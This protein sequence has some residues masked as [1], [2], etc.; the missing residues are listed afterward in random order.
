MR[1]SIALFSFA[2][3]IVSPLALARID[4]K[5]VALAAETMTNWIPRVL[6]P[7]SLR[8]GWQYLFSTA[9]NAAARYLPFIFSTTD[10]ALLE[11]TNGAMRVVIN[12]VL[13]TRPAVSSA[14]A[15]G[16]FDTNL[17]SWTDSDEAGATS[18]WVT[19]GYMG[20]TG[21]GTS[22]A[23][24]D[25]QVTVA[26]GDQNVEHA[27]RIVIQ[28]GPVVL[29]V[30]SS[31][32][33]DSYINETTLNTG[34]H[35]LAFTPTGNFWIRFLS[36]LERQT[37]VN[38][39]NVEGSGVVSITSPYLA[40]DLANIR[41]DQSGDVIFVACPTYQQ[42]RIERRATRSWSIALY[43]ADDGP[44]MVE[45]TDD[46][47]TLTASAITGNIT[48]TASR[49]LFRSTQVG[50]IWRI[51]SVGQTVT[52]SITAQNQFSDAIRITGVGTDRTFTITLTNTWTATVTLQ[53]SFASSTG[54]W[55][56]VSGGVW[57]SNVVYAA[58]EGYDNQ[59]VWYRIG[60]KTG[61]F[62]SGQVDAQLFIPTG[63]IAGVAR[64][65]AFSSATSVSAEVL[66]PLGGTTSTEVWSEGKWSD[67]RGWPTAVRLHEGRLWWFG[68]NGVLGSISDV[69]D[70]FDPDYEGDA[71]PINRTIGSGPVDTIN[72]GLSLQRLLVGAQGAEHSIRSSS[73]DEPLTPTNFKITPA[74][75]QGSAA[76]D[77]A[78]V[79]HRGVYVARSGIKLYEL[80]LDGSTYEYTSNDLT[81][82]CPELGS[83]GIV[84]LA[85][86]R[87]P[88]TRIHAV[89]SDGTV[90]LG[91]YDKAEEV[92]AWLNLETDGD[93]EDV[94]VLPGANA[95]TEDKV[96]Y[97]VNR[98]IN[99]ATVRY[100]EKWAKDTECRGGT[101]NKQA[102]AFVT[103]ANAP[104]STTISG[105]THLVGESVVVWQDGT[106]PED[107]S[108]LLPKTF[109]VSAGGAI[110]VDTAATTGIVGLP[111]TGQ[112]KSAKL[113]LQPS[114]A[115]TV[116][117]KE[118]RLSALGLLLA[119][120]HAKGL[121]YGPD[122]DH[123]NDLPGIE[124]GTAVSANTVHTTYDESP[125]IFPGTW[126]TDNRLCLD[127]HAPRPCTVLAAVVD[128][129]T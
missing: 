70:G 54:P 117:T 122:F 126:T 113:G 58:A 21:T 9:S 91:V 64:L 95:S 120:T 51:T 50:G 29:R 127:A 88:D 103:F 84:R 43:L 48:L 90:M 82:L 52:K 108:T 89:R 83:P 3:G 22:A 26:G 18:A 36:R 79:D 66:S 81:S 27:L 80:A 44:F 40:A 15:N 24:R 72:W 124:D 85:V 121:R 99:S 61:D 65:T 68:K 23:I 112:W 5:R 41:F 102:D 71:A 11:F 8:P 109:T 57:T 45:N 53:R 63:S 30:G 111:Y 35:S 31:Q 75:T 17:T 46:S 14:V 32:G 87:Q 105:L 123:L 96:Y 101:T 56:D 6:G 62:T 1:E 110:T 97:V 118:K 49:A 86:Q 100:L 25:Q 55:A 107:S 106:C 7:M 33:D 20:L 114:I 78:R 74:S 42:R 76:V 92:M 10:T 19:G 98:T 13:L 116:L 28:R 73:L 39:C 59:E 93:V 12:D 4:Q 104:A 37:L 128:L 16:N 38:S 2:R 94:V 77:P 115:Q 119:W 67:Y 34:T 60:V 69:F 129:K 125:F 47:L